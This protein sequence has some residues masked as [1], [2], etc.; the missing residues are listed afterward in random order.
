[1]I[2]FHNQTIE[3]IMM[4]LLFLCN[5]PV[6]NALTVFWKRPITTK[7]SRAGLAIGICLTTLHYYTA[8]KLFYIY[9]LLNQWLITSIAL[10]FNHWSRLLL[11]YHLFLQSPFIFTILFYFNI[12]SW[13]TPN[14]VYKFVKQISVIIS[15]KFLRQ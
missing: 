6:Q 8:L 13:S 7:F 3:Y 9:Y 11:V 12:E 15:N 4:D 1:M 2:V 14:Y 10:N 5:S